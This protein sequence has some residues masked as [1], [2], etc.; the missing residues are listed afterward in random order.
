MSKRYNQIKLSI[1]NHIEEDGQGEV[2]TVEHIK[3]KR[4]KKYKVILHN[5][6]YTTMD[7]VI[8]VLKSIFN[9]TGEQAE[10]I[11]WK[12]HHEGFGVCGIY[13]FEIAET[14]TQKVNQCAK[15]HSHPL[16]CS[17]EEE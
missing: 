3:V 1:R 15:E 4:P 12:I 11:M 17:M 5:D 16:K 6:D 10:A 13:S 8:H 7:F 9:K 14:K 2:G